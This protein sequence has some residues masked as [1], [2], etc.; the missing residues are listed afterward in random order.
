MKNAFLL[1]ALLLASCATQ[2]AGDDRLPEDVQA[3]VE[4]REMCDY[5]RGE[6]PDGDDVARMQTV[7]LGI[8]QYCSS[9][10]EDLASLKA[11]YARHAGVM[12]KLAGY[13]ER[14]EAG[15]EP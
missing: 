4:R 12:A 1:A 2:G 8:S 13:E 10:D 3:F 9:T 5:F 6:I 14:I 15:R 7:E 11:R